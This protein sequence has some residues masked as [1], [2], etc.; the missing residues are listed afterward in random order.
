MDFLFSCIFHSNLEELVLNGTKVS[1]QHDEWKPLGLS[2][3]VSAVTLLAMNGLL[4]A[5]LKFRENTVNF[6]TKLKLLFAMFE[7]TVKI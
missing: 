5:E 7:N 1:D 2:S 6:R 3:F 4:P